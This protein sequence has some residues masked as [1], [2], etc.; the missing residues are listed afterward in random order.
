LGES[1]NG[2]KTLHFD[3][4]IKLEFRGGKVTTDAGLLAIRELD[5]VLGL[6]DMAKCM[7][8]EARAGFRRFALP[9]EISAW[10]LRSIQLKLVKIGAKVVSHAR[11]TIFQLAEVAISEALFVKMLARIHGLRYAPA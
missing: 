6:T 8:S 3:S 1:K 7:L 11:R 10:S 9:R 5:E 2:A 4:G